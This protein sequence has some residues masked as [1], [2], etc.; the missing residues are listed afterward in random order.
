MERAGTLF[1]V[2]ISYATAGGP[3]EGKESRR[4]GDFYASVQARPALRLCAARPNAYVCGPA[5]LPSPDPDPMPPTPDL[6]RLLQVVAVA[7]NEASTASSA[8]RI[9][10]EAVCEHTGWQLG[11]AYLREADGSFG[12]SGIWHPRAP[13]I[14]PDFRDE[15][16]RTRFAPG[17]GL[18]GRV[19]QTGEP[20]WIEDIRDDPD[21][22]RT[23]GREAGLRAAV[24][25]PVLV[26]REVAG[27]LEFFSD[28]PLSPDPA[29]LEVMGNVGTQLGRVIERAR[30][31]EALRLSEAKFAG[32]V[33]ISSDAIVSIG[34]DQR[35]V[36]FNH[37]A[38]Q[39]FGY[40][41]GEVM[42]KRIEI[43][44]PE[45]FRPDHEAQVRAFGAS[46]IEARR[47][48]E[49]GQISGRRKSGEI[50]PA[51]ASI[52][53]IEVAGSRIYTAVLRDVTER[54]RAAE[55]L[56]Q[57]A[58]ELA[59]SN[60]D[61]EQFA[62]VASHDLQ[63]PLRMVASYTQLLAR[64]YRD[65]LD[66]DAQEFIGYAVDGVTRMQSLISDLLAYSRVGS[67][68]GEV[69][70]VDADALLGRILDRTLAAAI[71][72]SGATV[73]H[74]PLPTVTGDAVQLGQVLQNLVANALKFRG[75][76]PPRVHVGAEREGD[77]WVISVRDNGIGISPEYAQRIFV[78]FQRLHSRG[79]YA[80]TGI[81]L[82]ICKKIVERHGG[83]IWVESAP[84][85]G[86]TFR[87]TLPA[88]LEPR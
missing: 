63:E 3:E 67:R 87:F 37:G 77:E 20:A 56:A 26:G 18:V 36:F 51:D 62:Y 69:A 50:F 64:R 61:L 66:D 34:E 39:T 33:S 85:Q 54:V 74:D 65:Q 59:R 68:D 80:G 57:Q 84:G 16:A 86:S 81:G 24:A 52:S 23:A 76:E 45:R 17:T 44:I 48:G 47:M 60:A 9:S 40:T 75:D 73:T 2:P 41:A 6:V 79:E 10:L 8:I 1:P 12:P 4:C 25:F 55:A 19:A 42:G 72:E 7:A 78:I 22:V 29:L 38:E 58:D 28:R 43:L 5:R 82:A 11:H 70:P 53:R 27:A 83:R 32:I 71:E 13:G 35:I 14:F 88:D 15:T 30:S 46:P 21:F 49:R 31:E